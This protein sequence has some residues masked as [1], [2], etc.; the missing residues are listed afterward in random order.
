[1]VQKVG[2]VTPEGTEFVTSDNPFVTFVDYGNGRL[3]AGWGLRKNATIGVFPIAPHVCLVMGST[4]RDGATT[5]AESVTLINK[6]VIELCERYVHSKTKSAEIRK[7]VDKMA[8]TKK[9]GVHAFLPLDMKVP[10]AK[11]FVLHFLGLA[12]WPFPDWIAENRN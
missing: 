7:A 1:M 6:V 5:N 11:D 2:L 10:T 3:N 9:Y 8:N 12:P 4:G